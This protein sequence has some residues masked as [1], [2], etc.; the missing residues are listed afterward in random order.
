MI[1]ALLTTLG[2]LL[3]IAVFGGLGGLFVFYKF[4][5]DLPDYRQLANYE[6]PVMTR[7]HAGDGRLLAEYAVEKRVFVPIN[8]MPKKVIQAFLAAEDKN[9]YSHAGID[10]IGVARAVIVN[11]KNVGSERR[12]VGA[13]TITQ[14]VAK[15]FLLSN[16]VSWRRK[17]KEAILALRIERAFPKDRI[18]ELYL[19]EIYLGFGSYGVAAAALNY[20]NRSL[21]ELSVAEMAFLGALPKAPNN[22]NPIRRADAAR[23][24]RD[25][26]IGRMHEEGYI[27]ADEA[28]KARSSPLLIAKRDDTEFVTAGYFAEE[29]RRELE[30]R[31]GEQQLYKGGLSVRTTIDPKL[32]AMADAALRDGLRAYD[33]RHG[34]RGPIAKLPAEQRLDTSPDWQRALAKVPRPKGI[35]EWS[36][37][38]VLGTDKQFAFVGVEDG[39][40]GRIPLAEL[41][42]AREALD[43][44][45]RGAKVTKPADVLAHG[46]VILVSRAVSED[47]NKPYPEDFYG[48]RQIPLING[49]IVALDP[50]TGRVLAMSGGYSIEVS[51][52]NR[53]TQARRQP[54]SAFKPFVYLAAL[55]SGFTPST[56]ILDAPFVIDQGPGLPKWRPANYT[57]KFY[58][59]ST[60]RLGIEK[61]RNLMTVR[62]AQT[63]GMDKVATY[64]KR[65]GIVDNMPETLAMSLGAGETTLLRLT[66]AYA[67]LVN[68]GKRVT[69][70]FIDRIQDRNGRTVY[71]HDGR[72]CPQCRAASWT[73]Q[74]VPELPDSRDQ[75]TNPGSAYQIVAML[76]GVV[77]RGTGRRISSV[78][79]PL[80]GKTG[81]TNEERDTWFMGF[82]PD[83]VVGVF[84]GMDN[85]VPLGNNETGSAVAAPV[86]RDFMAAALKDKPSIP[87]RIPPNIRLVRVDA[88]TGKVAD[89]GTQD[90]ILE[91][92]KPGTIPEGD[93]Q[94]V[95]GRSWTEP[96]GTTASGGTITGTG[97]LY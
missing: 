90:I 70:T 17:V 46:D 2:L 47:K 96:G 11:L 23:G 54:G 64:A 57:N 25:W 36:L 18:L 86:F 34:Y 53:V 89:A 58:G 10:P 28:E 78:G 52:F 14:Q 74:R 41:T 3:I 73:R 83:L 97:G 65:F 20:F 24:R 62:L 44:Q 80:A 49:G 76:Q 85:P 40:Q 32:Q 88:R 31:Y 60:M 43:D 82:S 79:K 95:E 87:F 12:L 66:T 63:V 26:V 16:E 4:G 50:H 68:G 51:Q 13:S 93:S 29:V 94:V 55:D 22:Y 1:R 67:M 77:E 9:F 15:N 19:N 75:I 6:P 92:F 33:R 8:A 71:R 45:K 61:S 35:E 21:D 7:V 38:V 37:G 69:P 72:D 42:W 48:L 39:K 84:C 59:P 27:T 56:L 91:A 5:Q 81:T 30:S